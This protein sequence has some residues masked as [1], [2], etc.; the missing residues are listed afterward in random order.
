LKRVIFLLSIL[1][2]TLMLTAQTNPEVPDRPWQNIR[3]SAYTENDLIHIRTEIPA[4]LANDTDFFFNQYNNWSSGALNDLTGTTYEAIIPANPLLDLQ[5]RF[6]TMIENDFFD[7]PD[8]PFPPPDSLALMLPGYIP[9]N[10]FPPSLGQMSHVGDDPAGDIGSLPADLDLISHRFSTSDNRIY[11]ALTNNTGSYPT[12]PLWGPFNVYATLIFNPDTV[13]RDEVLYALV[14]VSI[15]LTLSSGLYRITDL[16]NIGSNSFHRIGNISQQIINGTLVKGCNLSDLVN[17]PEFGEWPNASNSLAVA[18]MTVRLTLSI[19]VTFADLGPVAVMYFDDQIIE[20]FVNTLPL[21]SGLEIYEDQAGSVINVTY[22]DHE[23]NF[24]IVS[25][26]LSDTGVSYPFET[27]ETDFQQPVLYTAQL[28]FINAAGTVRFSDNGYQFSEIPILPSPFN[29]SAEAG[30]NRIHLSWNMGRESV[31]GF[32]ED[33]AEEYE[34]DGSDR[35][36]LGYNVYRDGDQINSSLIEDNSF[37]DTGVIYGSSYSYYVTAVFSQG[38]SAPSAPIEASPILPAP[39]DLTATAGNQ[40]VYLNWTNPLADDPERTNTLSSGIEDSGNS[41]RNLIGFNIYRNGEQI[42]TEPIAGNEYTDDQ[43]VYDTAYE[44]YLT[45]LYDE[46][47]SDSSNTAEAV[48]FILLE[49]YGLTAE[50]GNG[51]IHLTWQEPSYGTW[52]HWDN[53]EHYTP[54]GT[55]QPLQFSAAIR[56]PPNEL[57]NLGLDSKYL[58]KISFFPTFQEA[59]YEINVWTGGSAAAPGTLIIEQPVLSP[60]I[61]T[62]NIIELNTPVYINVDQELWFGYGVTTPGGHPA[63]CDSGPAVNGQG[64]MMFFNGQWTTLLALGPS[65]NYNWNIQGYTE[66]SATREEVLLSRER[67]NL[68]GYNLYRDGEM[69]NAELLIGREYF[70]YDLQFAQT[71][72]YYVTAVYS[73]GVSVPSNSTEI[74]YDYPL[75]LDVPDVS[76]ELDSGEV[77]LS[78]DLVEGASS[79]LIYISETPYT[80][81]WGE[82]VATISLPFYSEP[83]ISGKRFFRIIASTAPIE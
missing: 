82:P 80:E 27:S 46:G 75:E 41:L 45:T 50:T 76:I 63:G 48:P 74:T 9:G 16:D 51:F 54:I 61:N 7:I 28:P 52:I 22:F 72:E 37:I 64:N 8:L 14:R 3:N 25:E 19:D 12:G 32:T 78:W 43:V 17:D 73:E 62:W 13:L 71:Y 68:L 65:L 18:S 24:P 2:T 4:D 53:G 67:Q 15:P 70:D 60:V 33:D 56:F 69:I 77:F 21:L 59:S 66:N 58:T 20:P 36:Q 34:T 83:V 49:P 81:N 57:Q 23:A 1:L 10:P 35:T 31:C 79:Y 44:Y 40:A 6:R 11:S 30:Y 5:L 55:G 38:E 26:F 39:Y 29:L 47:E 42:N